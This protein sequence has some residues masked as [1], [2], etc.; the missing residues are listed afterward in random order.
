MQPI[1]I[2]FISIEL[3]NL[4]FF[5]VTHTIQPYYFWRIT[6]IQNQFP[7][8][9]RH[10][11]QEKKNLIDPMRRSRTCSSYPA[12]AQQPHRERERIGCSLAI[13]RLRGT[14]LRAI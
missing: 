1:T 10:R 14:Y 5:F 3:S 4:R 7:D 12:R 8:L 9:P 2:E 11:T 13:S 6:K